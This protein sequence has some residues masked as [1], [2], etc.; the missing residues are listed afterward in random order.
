MILLVMKWPVL[1]VSW[2]EWLVTETCG[3]ASRGVIYRYAGFCTPSIIAIFDILLVKRL[4]L[5]AGWT[6]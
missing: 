6:G 1:M 3:G 4:L 5:I 2:A